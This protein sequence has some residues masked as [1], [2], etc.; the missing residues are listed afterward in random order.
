MQSVRLLKILLKGQRSRS[1]H[2][3]EFIMASVV[4][5]WLPRAAVVV[6]WTMESDL[7]M[8]RRGSNRHS[9]NSPVVSCSIIWALFLPSNSCH[10]SLAHLQILWF[11][12]C[13]LIG[14]FTTISS[15]ERFCCSCPVNF[16]PSLLFK[17][18]LPIPSNQNLF[19]ITKVF[20]WPMC[21]L[22]FLE[23]YYCLLG[24]FFFM[25]YPLVVLC[26]EISGWKIF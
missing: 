19:K 10:E 9:R 12:Q 13:H 4:D 14:S 21:S 6:V 7:P 24:S 23:F 22:K 15:Q 2:H 1:K 3:A 11:I 16:T 20:Y 5:I 18:T 25:H 8:T 26:A 17:D